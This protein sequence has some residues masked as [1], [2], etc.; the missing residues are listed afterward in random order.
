MEIPF[1]QDQQKIPGAKLHKEALA[2]LFSKFHLMRYS[3]TG[4]PA[5]RMTCKAIT[6][7]T[8]LYL[9][10]PTLPTQQASTVAL[11]QTYLHLHVT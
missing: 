5:V 1:N 3:V 11:M 6:P 8:P 9:D 4:L 10:V 7:S 2:R